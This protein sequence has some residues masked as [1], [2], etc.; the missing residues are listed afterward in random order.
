MV[1]W[2][3]GQRRSARVSGVSLWVAKVEVLYNKGFRRV[4]AARV[5]RERESSF[6]VGLVVKRK[7]DEVGGPCPLAVVR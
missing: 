7:R 1:E 3:A 6:G 4:P 2:H 5:A